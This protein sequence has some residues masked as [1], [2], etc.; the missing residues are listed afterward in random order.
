[1]IYEWG[2]TIVYIAR[3]FRHFF[4]AL[5]CKNYF[6]NSRGNAR[7]KESGGWC[8]YEVCPKRE[9]SEE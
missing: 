3:C 8:D 2:R 1:M 5:V 4:R 6:V 9:R 7:C